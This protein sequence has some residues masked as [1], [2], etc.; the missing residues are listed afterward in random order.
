MKCMNDSPSVPILWMSA[1][2]YLIHRFAIHWPIAWIAVV[3]PVPFGKFREMISRCLSIMLYS[4]A[5]SKYRSPLTWQLVDVSIS[6]LLCLFL[7]LTCCAVTIEYFFGR[8]QLFS[9]ILKC[10]NQCYSSTNSRW[11]GQACAS[12]IRPLGTLVVV[13]ELPEEEE[14]KACCPC[15][16]VILPNI[17]DARAHGLMKEGNAWVSLIIGRCVKDTKEAACCQQIVAEKRKIQVLGWMEWKYSVK[18]IEQI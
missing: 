2:R 5:E 3:V 10:W 7:P 12:V 1:R 17:Y 8:G 14:E 6:D 16:E 9:K 15:G 18:N 4:L 13:S 11:L